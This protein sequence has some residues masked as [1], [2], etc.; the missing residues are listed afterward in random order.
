MPLVFAVASD[1]R[2][3]APCSVPAGRRLS[4]LIS[5]DA[6]NVQVHHTCRRTPGYHD[7]ASSMWGSPARWCLLTG[8]WL[9]TTI[10]CPCGL[11]WSCADLSL[12][13]ESSFE[14]SFESSASLLVGFDKLKLKQTVHPYGLEALCKLCI[15]YKLCF[16]YKL[17]CTIHCVHA[18][19]SFQS[20]R[21]WA[22]SCLWSTELQKT[23]KRV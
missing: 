9:P 17:C 14:S 19:A 20:K 6:T 7:I 5:S 21:W 10:G 18:H 23:C 15:L 13:V 4:P 22:Q 8:R 16:V 3:Y 11:A 2:W 1:L 12:S